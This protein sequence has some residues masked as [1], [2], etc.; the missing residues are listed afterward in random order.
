MMLS[1]EFFPYSLGVLLLNFNIRAFF[2]FFWKIN[3]YLPINF[4]FSAIEYSKGDRLFPYDRL[5]VA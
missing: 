3:K 5:L 2:F 1:M 4:C